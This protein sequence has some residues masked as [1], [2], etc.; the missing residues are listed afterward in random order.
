M[1]HTDQHPMTRTHTGPALRHYGNHHRDH[2]NPGNRYPD[3]AECVAWPD[4]DEPVAESYTEYPGAIA[5]AMFAIPATLTALFAVLAL[6]YGMAGAWI[7]GWTVL[8]ILTLAVTGVIGALT[9][10]SNP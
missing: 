2:F 3:C 7:N 9:Y 10:R 1:R 5:A 4:L 8:A 6:I